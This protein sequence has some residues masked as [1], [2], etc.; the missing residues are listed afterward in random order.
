MFRLLRAA[1]IVVLAAIVFQITFGPRAARR[2]LNPDEPIAADGSM[3]AGKSRTIYDTNPLFGA[4]GAPP[5]TDPDDPKDF[6][7][8]IKDEKWSMDHSRD[9]IAALLGPPDWSSCENAAR[10]KLIAAVQIY[11][12]TRGGQKYS[13][14]LRG[15]RAKAAIEKEWST[16]LDL[17]IDEFVRR[18][19]QSGFIHKNEVPA[20]V[21][22]EFAKTFA[23]IKEIGVMCP[24]LKADRDTDKL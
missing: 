10:K 23:D 2:A 22:P 1:L 18:A 13:F 15:P 17:R 3:I 19:L 6:E 24:P 9:A 21:Y 7:Q 16:P 11:Y 14:A 12:R 5:R 8:R 20:N 4:L